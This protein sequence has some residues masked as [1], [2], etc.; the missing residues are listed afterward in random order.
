MSPALPGGFFT[1]EPQGKPTRT[2][3]S[4][5]EPRASVRPTGHLLSLHHLGT[6][7]LSFH[8]ESAYVVSQTWY[9]TS[10]QLNVYI[11]IPHGCVS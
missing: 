4:S 1:T 7:F 3:P 8:T 6:D 5:K 10:L 9:P 2:V 11:N